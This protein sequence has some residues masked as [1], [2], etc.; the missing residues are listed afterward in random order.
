MSEK[1]SQ[2]GKNRMYKDLAWTF[3]IISQPEE[4]IEEG[5][6][7]VG[8]IRK[9]SRKEA[10]TLLN[11]GC[12]AG[13]L[14]WAL[15]KN[16]RI[17]SVDISPQMLKVARKINPE[18]EYL[19]GDMRIFRLERRFDTV[20]IHDAINY[21]LSPEEL[22]SAFSTAYEHLERGGILVT[23]AEEWPE[24]FVQNRVKAF[25]RVKDDVEITLIEHFYDPDRSDTTYE[26]TFVFLI[27]RNGMLKC[28]TDLHVC[29]IMPLGEWHQALAESGFTVLEPE[30]GYSP[31]DSE[32]IFVGLKL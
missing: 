12:G 8:E 23:F 19:E 22:R 24:R 3:P 6:T 11:L 28:E 25:T 2:P 15:K 16:F 4:Y 5:E 10:R 13:C 18:V 21:M 7:F 29:G 31:G 9:H 17:T 32:T 14:D 20:V 1:T 30:P 26:S 27:R